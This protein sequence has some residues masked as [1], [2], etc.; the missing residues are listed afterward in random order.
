MSK[1][2]LL[3]ITSLVLFLSIFHSNVF[4]YPY[5]TS[6][7][8]RLGFGYG[9]SRYRQIKYYKYGSMDWSSAVNYGINQINSNPAA[10]SG[11]FTTNYNNC[12]I[13][14]S[15]N[16]WPSVSWSGVTTQVINNYSAQKTIKLNSTYG[17]SEWLK[18][19][20]ATHEFAHAW[21]VTDCENPSSIECGYDNVRQVNYITSDVTNLFKDRYN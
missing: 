6:M 11:Y 13:V 20:I 19:G 14:L 8:Y 16:Y 12:N 5:D 1:K 21:G 2:I 18:N 10:V 4:A 17:S 3:S 9:S 7:D 15:S